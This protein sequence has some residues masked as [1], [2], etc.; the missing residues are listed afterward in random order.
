MIALV[1]V[2]L[3]LSA[4]L[5]QRVH[6]LSS[7]LVIELVVLTLA[8]FHPMIGVW[9]GSGQSLVLPFML[10]LGAC[11]AALALAVLVLLVRSRGNDQ[12]SALTSPL[13]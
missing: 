8:C 3:L 9:S 2:R 6:F 12:L 4:L 11:E 13:F 7:L 10:A 1:T 5:R